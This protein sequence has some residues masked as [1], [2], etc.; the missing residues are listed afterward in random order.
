MVL[1]EHLGDSV[2]VHL[3]LDGSE[4][5]LRAKLSADQ[6]HLIPGQMV[7]IRAHDDHILK[8]NAQGLRI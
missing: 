3:R 8:F 6:G 4:E 7:G 2:I 5:L 1:A